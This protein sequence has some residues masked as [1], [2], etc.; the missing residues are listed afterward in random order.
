MSEDEHPANTEDSAWASFQ[1]PLEPDALRE[2]CLD[3][4]RL[5]RINPYLEFN[6]WEHIG[7]NRYRFSGRNSSQEPALDFDYLL[8][9]NKTTDGLVVSYENALK[10]STNFKVEPGEKGAQLTITEDYSGSTTEERE[11]RINEVDKSLVS[12]ANDLQAYLLT[13]HRWSWLWP[14]RWYMRKI[15]Q[16]LK[17][18]G[19]RIVYMFIW[20]SIVEVA[21]IALGVTIYW[22]EYT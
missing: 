19:R 21:L 11:A 1:T 2:F 14:W 17:P 10:T 7:E 13:W 6:Q 9:A 8:T 18:M 22:A 12:W 20:I 5:F 3:V 16:P 4:E 15:W